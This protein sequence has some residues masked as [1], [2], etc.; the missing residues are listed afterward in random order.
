M[1]PMTSYEVVKRAID[2][3]SPDRLP[4]RVE[5]LGISD[6]HSLNW[7]QIGTGDHQYKETLDEWG[8][9]WARTE[10]RN[11]GQVKGHP[12]ENLEA[13]DHYRWPDPED[14][15][16]YDG[17]EAEFIGSQG[18]YIR[19]EFFMLLFERMCALHGFE[20]T[21]IDPCRDGAPG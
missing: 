21:L 12:L 3:G 20:N 10:T 5:T 18:K 6:I 8:C 13:L 11:M 15:V 19:C 16:F 4:V 9:R 1:A 17:M 14:P 7:N 2:F